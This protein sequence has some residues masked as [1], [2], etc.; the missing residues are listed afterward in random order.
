MPKPKKCLHKTKH[1]ERL[2]YDKSVANEH[3]RYCIATYCAD[4]GERL[5]FVLIKEN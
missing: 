4:C 3:L 5:N 1:T 2:I